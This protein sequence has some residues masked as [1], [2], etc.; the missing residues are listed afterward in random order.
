M[1]RLLEQSYT[2]YYKPELNGSYAK[3]GSYKIIFSFTK[4][5]PNLV[6]NLKT[7]DLGFKNLNMSN[8]YQA[9]DEN[10]IVVA[11]SSSLNGLA[12]L[13]GLSIAGVK[14]HLNRESFVYAKALGLNVN[15][16]KEGLESKGKPMDFYRSKKITRDTLNLN[17]LPLSS[18]DLGNIYV[19][20][21]D[22]KTILIKKA[23]SPEAS[24]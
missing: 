6:F 10:K 1:P 24:L 19:F 11:S 2:L 8:T 13:L 16:I 22:K 23:S 7:N 20:N 12:S 18:L 9:I 4:W 15:I 3:K 17:N 14:Y 21:L 5:D